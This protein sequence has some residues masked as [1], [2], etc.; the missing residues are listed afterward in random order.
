MLTRQD[1]KWWWS[2]F[3][4]LVDRGPLHHGE[5]NLSFLYSNRSN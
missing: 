3:N 1:R 4:D 5:A 2:G